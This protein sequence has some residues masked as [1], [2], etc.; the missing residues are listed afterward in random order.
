MRRTLQVADVTPRGLVC[1][2]P[3]GGGGLRGAALRASL[4]ATAGLSAVLSVTLAPS[5]AAS[6]APRQVA[7]RMLPALQSGLRFSLTG[8]LRGTLS[9]NAAQC[10]S[11]L[12]DNGASGLIVI[13]EWRTSLAG[14]SALPGG[15]Q[16][17]GPQVYNVQ[18]G[19]S[20]TKGGT[21][22][23][24]LSQN[25]GS[26]NWVVLQVAERYEYIAAN[27]T[28]TNHINSGRLSVGLVPDRHPTGPYLAGNGDVH[29]SGN[30]SCPKP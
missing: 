30:W 11:Q 3:R 4:V 17:V 9:F 13:F 25:Q 16:M 27:G 26:G 19:D 7:A 8:A 21:F 12:L 29:L 6:L 5:S 20:S 28:F 1:G 15:K 2:A 24:A 23:G 18:I 14:L 10:K 22:T